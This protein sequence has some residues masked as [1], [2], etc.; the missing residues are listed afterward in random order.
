MKKSSPINI[1]FCPY[2]TGKTT[3]ANNDKDFIDLDQLIFR[4]KEN[5]GIKVKNYYVYLTNAAV[6]LAKQGYNVLL[7]MD[8]ATMYEMSS[9]NIKYYSIFVD[10]S[11]S[12]MIENRFNARKSADFD[13]NRSLEALKN[14][15]E[16]VLYNFDNIYEDMKHDTPNLVYKITDENY[17]LKEIINKMKENINA[18]N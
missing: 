5:A 7:V 10:P 17:N 1:F 2:C 16:E 15:T 13:N 14:R 12:Y 11:L 4:E 3:L 8:Q 9:R 6:Y 18:Q